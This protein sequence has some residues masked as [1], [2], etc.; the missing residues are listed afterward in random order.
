MGYENLKV[1]IAGGIATVTVDRPKALNALNSQTLRE[2]AAVAAELEANP[3]V[4]AL[5]LTG[6][7]EKA[8]VAGADISEMAGFT[9]EQGR[10]FSA[11]GHKA[12][13]ALE[14]LPFPTI[15]AIN[16]FALGGGLELALACD[17]LYASEKAKLGFPEASL[18]VIP[19]F[20]GTQRLTRLVGKQRAKELVLT[21]DRIDA[22]KAREYGL[23]LEV[24]P[25][26]QLM[27]HCRAVA[28][29]ILKNGPVAVA[30][31]KRLIEQGADLDL[32]AANALEQQAFGVMFGTRDQ[33]EGMEAF[34]AKRPAS[35]EGR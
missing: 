24:L 26:D 27:A 6:G 16:G 29:R 7:G 1:E 10:A 30:Q 11:V 9:S 4:R 3:A 2:V 5:I 32:G 12:F 23:L 17:L 20:G 22:A 34:L 13:A 19:G 21:G 8:F 15:A 31:G 28:E 33:K 18:A 14:A 35:Y 25:A